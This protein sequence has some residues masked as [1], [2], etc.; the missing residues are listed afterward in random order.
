MNQRVLIFDNNMSINKRHNDKGFTLV[1][2]IVSILIFG[3]IS[4]LLGRLIVTGANVYESI[5]NRKEIKDNLY[6][7]QRKLNIDL[8]GLRDIQH[9]SYAD[10]T[11]LRF[12][13]SSLDTIQYR[14]QSGKLYR[15]QNS[16]GEHPIAQYLTDSTSFSYYTIQGSI[17]SE[18]PLSSSSLL[19]IWLVRLDLYAAKGTQTMKIQ[20]ATFPQNLKY[21]VVKD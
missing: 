21:G 4:I 1:E 17:I 8:F 10:K 16:D 9:I 7:A 14:Y 3:I 12:I 11:I 5:F 2:V 20:T 6:L 18:D 13:N 19:T 15:N